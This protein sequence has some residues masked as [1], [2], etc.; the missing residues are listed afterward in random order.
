MR[1]S[2]L[3]V[4]YQPRTDGMGGVYFASKSHILGGRGPSDSDRMVNHLN[5]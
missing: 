2:S 1:T 4:Q 3:G 5:V